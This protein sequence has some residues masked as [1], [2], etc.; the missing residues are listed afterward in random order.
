[1]SLQSHAE[2]LNALDANPAFSIADLQHL[3]SANSKKRD[4]S[5][6]KKIFVASVSPQVKASLAV[7][8]GTT[9]QEAGYM[10]EQLFC[11]PNGLALGGRYG[12]SFAWIVE[13]NAMREICLAMGTEE[14]LNAAS[15]SSS[16]TPILTSACPGWVCYAEK[17]HPHV[18][19]YLSKL[20][21]PQALTGT[22]L[23]SILS[24]RLDVSP[25][26]IFHLAVMP[27]FDKKLEGS[28]QELTSKSWQPNTRED[29]SEVRDVDCVITAREILMLADSRGISFPSL[30]RTPVSASIKPEFPDKLIAGFLFNTDGRSRQ[31]PDSGTSGGYLHY[32]IQEKQRQHPG[33][34]IESQRGRNT[35]VVD[36]SITL[37]GQTIFRA[38]R[39]YGFR[40]IQ[41]LVRKLRPTRISKL[42]GKAIGAARKPTNGTTTT[43]AAT[44]YA[45]VEVMACP[46]GCT[47]G[48]G[49]IKFEDLSSLQ[50]QTSHAQSQKEWLTLVDEAYYSMDESNSEDSTEPRTVD[51]KA[52]ILDVKSLIQHWSDI[53][54]IPAEKL[55]WTSFRE[56]HS[57]VGKTK[58]LDTE[59]VAE[60]ATKLGGG[61]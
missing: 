1:M 61:W 28:R 8:Y 60:I 15:G 33:S 56:V 22:L 24:Q 43:A 52:Q 59:R 6:P 53:T 55:L 19:P 51:E 34:T 10:I 30:P 26:D 54:N 9:Q 13:T 17:T 39:Y 41:N 40:N 2:V 31:N 23:K 4:D 29:Y 57:D 36:Y 3:T 47:N 48:G 44:E 46:G 12:S 11:G 27:C 38:S 58:K 16:H 5:V 49:Q 35:D 14:A 20:K 18:L 42:S 25:D 50:S 7:T 21:S 45:Y 37:N 32:I